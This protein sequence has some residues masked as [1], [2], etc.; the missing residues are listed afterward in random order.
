[1]KNL[2]I[3][4]DFAAKKFDVAVIYAE[5]LQEPWKDSLQAGK[6][7]TKKAKAPKKFSL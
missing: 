4:I 1:M 2:F 7:F 3:D 6:S 5:G